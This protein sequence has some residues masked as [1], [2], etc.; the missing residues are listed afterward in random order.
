MLTG[1]RGQHASGVSYATTPSSISTGNKE[2]DEVFEGAEIS[3]KGKYGGRKGAVFPGTYEE[4]MEGVKGVKG[5]QSEDKPD[6]ATVVGIPSE[7]GEITVV[8]Y[9]RGRKSKNFEKPG[10]TIS[11]PGSKEEKYKGVP[12]EKSK[13]PNEVEG[14]DEENT[15]GDSG[16]K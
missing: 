6:G 11:E 5:A 9:P 12:A 14:S 4:I 16:D 3:G 8:G 10:V 2:L 13:S 1:E 7:D 15:G